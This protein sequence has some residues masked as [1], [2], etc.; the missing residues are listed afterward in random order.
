MNKSGRHPK[1]HTSNTIHHVIMRGNN[2][3]NIFF[4]RKYFEYFLKVLAEASSKYD[5]KVLLYCL[6]TNHIHL[7]IRVHEST[8]SDIIKNISYRYVRWVNSKLNRIG[9]LFQGRYQSKLV[10]SEQYLVNLCR[11]IHQN[12]VEAQMVSTVDDYRWVS[13]YYYL[14]NKCPPWMDIIFTIYI[15][16]QK[17]KMTYGDFI[18]SKSTDNNWKPTLYIDDEGNFILNEKLQNRYLAGLPHKNSMKKSLKLSQV[19][20]VCCEILSVTVEALQ[21]GC[22]VRELSR[23][24]AIIT[25][26]A[27]KYTNTTFVE[28]ANI[29]HLTPAAINK[30]YLKIK[31]NPEKLL[32]KSQ[33]LKIKEDL[34]RL[35]TKHSK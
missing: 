14:L 13:H 8:L 25:Y 6:M 4:G 23:K 34:D 10:D 2:R 20:S 12:P 5:H 21:S 7:V 11:Y 17:T 26:H 1:I 28:I 27:L 32:P 30:A 15:I 22:R 29:F 31:A 24:R 19:I 35:L 9:H 16:I 18:T 3:Q 33:L